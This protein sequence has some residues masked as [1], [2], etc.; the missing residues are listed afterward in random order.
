MKRV[1]LVGLLVLGAAALAQDGKLQPGLW[2]VKIMHQVV[3]GKDNAAQLAAAMDQIRQRL[4]AMTPDQRKQM[5]AMMGGGMSLPEADGSV[6]I[7]ISPAMAA[8]DSTV[9][10]PTGHCPPAKVSR[11]GNVMSFEI[12]CSANGRNTNGKGTSTISGDAVETNV[13]VTLSDATA[14]HSMQVQTRM[15]YLGADCQ[16]IKPADQFAK[17]AGATR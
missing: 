6:H 16:G 15:S 10:D 1:M 2:S 13:D 4:A 8:K 9:A 11:S 7:C 5:E 12:A 14:S 3:D 17:G